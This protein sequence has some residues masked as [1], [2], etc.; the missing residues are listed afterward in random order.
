MRSSQNIPYADF[1]AGTSTHRPSRKFIYEILHNPTRIR[2]ED[3]PFPRPDTYEALAGDG[4]SEGYYVLV[5]SG[6]RQ[7]LK[8]PGG[9]TGRTPSA[10]T[11]HAP[12]PPAQPL[13]P[14]PGGALPLPWVSQ[15][16]LARLVA[17]LAVG[18]CAPGPPPI[19]ADSLYPARLPALAGPLA[20][21]FAP[22]A[23][24]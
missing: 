9:A 16:I 6:R 5:A 2:A 11:I 23:R 20:A 19:A 17:P 13:W 21:R 10:T 12:C 22:L 18:E 4:C 8:Q 1:I 3:G 7:A 24:I 14:D 15:A